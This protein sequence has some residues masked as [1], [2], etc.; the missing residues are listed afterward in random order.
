MLRTLRQDL[1][2]C[3]VRVETEITLLRKGTEVDTSERAL[4]FLE[5]RD[6]AL[7]N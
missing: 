5:L 1:K 6:L 3:V 4:L 7:W 2:T